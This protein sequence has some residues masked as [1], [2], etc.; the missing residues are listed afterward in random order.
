MV[1]PR[2]DL[3]PKLAYG[4]AM[5]VQGKKASGYESPDNKRGTEDVEHLIKTSNVIGSF[6][7]LSLGVPL[8][9]GK[10]GSWPS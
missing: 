1:L 10:R 7:L 4:R 3:T 9:K 5:N 8:K 2:H 6:S